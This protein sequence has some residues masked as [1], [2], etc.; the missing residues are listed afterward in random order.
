M[1]GT[2]QRSIGRRTRLHAQD[3][4]PMS[5]HGAYNK[6]YAIAV[7]RQRTLTNIVRRLLAIPFQLPRTDLARS[8]TH[9]IPMSLPAVWLRP[10]VLSH[11]NTVAV[12]GPPVPAARP[13]SYGASPG[14]TSTPY[15]ARGKASRLDIG[16]VVKALPPTPPTMRGS[17]NLKGYS[18]SSAKLISRR[19]PLFEQLQRQFTATQT[20]I[21]HDTI[22]HI[23]SAA[24]HRVLPIR[25]ATRP[26]SEVERFLNRPDLLISRHTNA[27]T[28]MAPALPANAPL[29]K[30]TSGGPAALSAKSLS[31]A[32]GFPQQHGDAGK[33]GKT[34][35][36]SA[37]LGELYLVASGLG[38]W[39]TRYLARELQR[40]RSG[41]VTGT[42]L[43]RGAVW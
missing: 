4:G 28:F 13:R 26:P 38:H 3:A 37:E 15:L 24:D 43:Y 27:A 10:R 19:P 17:A 12:A 22:R 34:K 18:H 11:V 2:L 30:G 33:Q 42:S 7:A 8:K 35:P 21:R 36:G 6:Y 1:M 29:P 39:I 41:V 9:A 23:D 40:P 20:A 25:A 32:S 16:R 5:L 31:L 14:R